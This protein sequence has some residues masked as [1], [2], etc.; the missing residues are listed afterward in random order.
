M[1]WKG[2]E[3]LMFCWKRNLGEAIFEQ[4]LLRQ[5]TLGTS[6]YTMLPTNKNKTRMIYETIPSLSY[7]FEL[8]IQC[9]EADVSWITLKYNNLIVPLQDALSPGSYRV[10]NTLVSPAVLWQAF[11][12]RLTEVTLTQETP[13]QGC[14]SAISALSFPAFTLLTFRTLSTVSTFRLTEAFRSGISSIEDALALRAQLR[15]AIAWRFASIT[16]I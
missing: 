2:P 13:F 3:V 5:Y 12:G 14:L 15:N 16:L 7:S 4:L 11:R 10:E 9:R 1:T 6:I 8:M